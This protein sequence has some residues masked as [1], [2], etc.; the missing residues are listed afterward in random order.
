[1]L[2]P[3]CNF[4][5][6][7]D[8]QFCGNCGRPR[9]QSASGTAGSLAAGQS[10]SVWASSANPTA[11]AT[12]PS[13]RISDLIPVQGPSPET[14]RPGR[15]SA[16]EE[17][18][19]Y[20]CAAVTVD[21]ALTETV[22]EHVLEEEHR[23]VAVTPG[24]DL[25]TV[26]KFAIAANRRRMIRDVVLFLILC[27]L[28]IAIVSIIGLLFVVP[29][30]IVAWLVIMIERYTSLYG[31]AARG[32][33]PG[34]F[35][36]SSAPEPGQGTFADRQLNRVAEAAHEGNVT[37][38]SAYPP[39]LGYGRIRSSW[40]VAVDITKPRGNFAPSGFTVLDLYDHLKREVARLDLPRLQ[41]SDRVFVNGAEI[42]NDGRFLPDPLGAPVTSV[43]DDTIR[44]LITYP[45]EH[46]RP[47]LTMSLTGWNGDIVVTT[48]V[49]LLLSQTD[50]FIETAHMVVPPLRES[51]KKVDELELAPSFSEF[52]GMVGST[53]VA[54]I[55]RLFAS[56]PSIA[57]ALGSGGRRQKKAR[58]VHQRRDY[59][60][61]ISLREAA[62]DTNWQR[63]FQKVDDAHYAQVVE[64]R[65]LR[66]LT[67]FLASHEI[68]TSSFESQ[69][70]TV[71]NNGVTISGNATVVADQIAA[72]AGAQAAAN[73]LNRI[74]GGGESGNNP[75]GGAQ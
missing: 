12:A 25:V 34:A 22:I 67:E 62:A 30:L 9:D 48:L 10:G 37:I 28:V 1:M 58:R 31:R 57:H 68:D 24:L 38:Y 19:R 6:P 39:F 47:Y 27:L 49:R 71:I 74:R 33:R 7:L 73:I 60:A 55:P 5:N 64:L 40:S 11:R 21:K 20:L 75:S 61:L 43:D 15:P 53:V 72:G 8:Y 70:Q 41:M 50:L 18:T 17:M 45:E 65:I 59:G 44:R 42:E 36:P 29:L 14:S 13:S 52:F 63:Y 56:I 2:C 32:L 35:D 23:A 54:T 26:L 46:A 69:T 16:G 3:L 4:D 51:F 66:S